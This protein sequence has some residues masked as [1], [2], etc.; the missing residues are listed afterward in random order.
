M[1]ETTVRSLRPFER[2]FTASADAETTAI[3]HVE[4]RELKT[5]AILKSLMVTESMVAIES[6]L[7]KGQSSPPHQHDDHESIVYLVRGKMKVT[8]DGEEFIA[9]P[10]DV[11]FNKPGVPHNL[12][13]LEDCVGFEVKSPPI[14]AW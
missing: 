3:T 8:I 14:K 11:W 12:E 1:T 2:S 4:G 13:A 7:A 5:P 10:G 6:T 9:G